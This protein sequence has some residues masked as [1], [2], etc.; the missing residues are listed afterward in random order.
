MEKR[1]IFF[2]N[3]M[4]L[5]LLYLTFVHPAVLNGL[6]SLIKDIKGRVF[7]VCSSSVLPIDGVVLI[8]IQEMIFYSFE[9]LS[10]IVLQM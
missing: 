10:F 7:N 1:V 6:Q 2:N 9:G 4:I 8:L 3:A 5:H